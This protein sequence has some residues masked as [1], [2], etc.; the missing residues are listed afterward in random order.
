MLEKVKLIIREETAELHTK[1]EIVRKENADLV[2]KC[3]VLDAKYTEMRAENA[4]LHF[5]L[6]QLEN[7]TQ[8]Y[9]IYSKYAL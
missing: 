7:H 4:N 3:E 1:Y 8:V 2:N 6:N 5:Q 9:L